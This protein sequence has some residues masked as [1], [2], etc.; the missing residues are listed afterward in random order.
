[1]KAITLTISTWAAIDVGDGFTD[2]SLFTYVDD[3]WDPAS[4]DSSPD[5]PCEAVTRPVPHRCAYAADEVRAAS[6]RPSGRSGR[7]PRTCR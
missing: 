7:P 1:M 3:D 2:W 5:A 4:H 6:G